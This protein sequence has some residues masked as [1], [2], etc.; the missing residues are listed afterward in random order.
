MTDSSID[1]AEPAERYFVDV[2]RR[3]LD[4]FFE[5][6]GAH[7]AGSPARNIVRYDSE[8]WYAE[9][10][11]LPEDGPD[12]SPR[13]LIGCQ[14]EPYK[15]PRR[16]R[17]DVMHTVPES[18]EERGYNLR[19]RYRNRRQLEEALRFVRD[20]IVN[21]YT[22]PYLADKERLLSLLAQRHDAIE[23]AWEDEVDEHNAAVFRTKAEGAFRAKDFASA[24]HYY[25]QIPARKLTKT[26]RAKVKYAKS[27]AD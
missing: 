18:K 25:E 15:D 4:D 27:H 1:R 3:V 14:E 2:S 24:V 10:L 26:D 20:R 17:V 16:N 7:Y 22:I 6:L 8:L 23:M 5:E 21:V 19:W 11:Y 9:V 13:L 12:Y